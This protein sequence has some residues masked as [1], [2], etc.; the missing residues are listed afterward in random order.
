MLVAKL[1]LKILA[2]RTLSI[3]GLLS[4]SMDLIVVIVLIVRPGTL[5]LHRLIADTIATSMMH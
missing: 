1:L 5:Q 4:A 3:R 2:F